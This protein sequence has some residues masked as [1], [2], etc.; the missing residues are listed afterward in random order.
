MKRTKPIAD[1]L[2]QARALMALW[3]VW[4]GIARGQ[5]ALPQVAL[6]VLLSWITD[7]LDGPLARRDPNGKESWVGKRD[8]E[9]DLA[10]SVGLSLYLLLS[11]YV[12]TWM[13]LGA[14][15][16]TLALW[17]GH[18]HQLAWPFYA[19]PYAVLVALALQAH[20]VWGW[21]LVLYLGGVLIMRWR[22]LKEQYLAEFFSIVKN[23]W[24]LRSDRNK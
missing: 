1:F 20:V 11:R 23:I 5:D 24:V 14:L 19:L 18:S 7:L 10:T 17:I 9:A 4:L 16:V 3:I 22:R 12:A 8:A 2:T 6:V 13:G 21:V 15:A